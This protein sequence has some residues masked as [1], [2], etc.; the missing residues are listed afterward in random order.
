M[1]GLLERKRPAQARPAPRLER[2]PCSRERKIS[3]IVYRFGAAGAALAVF[4]AMSWLYA[5]GGEDLYEN[6]L[7]SYG[8][9]PFRF[10]FVDAS[11]ALAAWECARQGVDVIV[12]DP[13][14]VLQRGYNYS[15]L[16]MAVA[17]IPLGVRD[18]MAVGW[19]LD[20]V[21]LL[22]LSLLPPPR[23]TLELVVTLVATL[24]TMVAFALERANPDILLFLLTLA[25]GLL[26]QYPLLMRVL[27][28]FLGLAAALVK[29]YPIMVLVITFRERACVFCL[30]GLAVA[31]S[32]A[33]FWAEYHVDIARGLPNI[34]RG[35]YNTDL[36]SAQ[37]VPFLIGEVAAAVTASPQV[38][39][40]AAGGLYAILVGACIAIC[41][42]LLRFTELRTALAALPRFDRTL[43]VIGSAIIVGCFFAGQSIGYRGVFLLFVVPG[44]LGIARNPVRTLRILGLGTSI[45]IVLLMWG[46][47]FR[48]A[49]YRMLEQSGISEAIAS[50]IKIQ[51]WLLRELCWW[52]TVS[53][54]LAVL[55][56]FLREVPIS[57]SLSSLFSRSVVR[58]G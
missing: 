25:T 57:R 44:L 2:P 23:R 55:A 4:L 22:S 14:D 52:W 18:T 24:S 50:E 45:V 21:F 26:T 20:L 15:P 6:I 46:E 9:L 8:V 5:H 29:Y 28:Y 30:V 11:G 10:P 27:G 38:W 49:L 40:I 16:W 13:C 3:S 36:F 54:M 35:P 47:C 51:F 34:A 39:Q 33:V 58:L 1:L 43:L 32:L 12:S 56:D 31:A 53:V 19:S 37:N 17:G 41:R 42:R 7:I 48:L